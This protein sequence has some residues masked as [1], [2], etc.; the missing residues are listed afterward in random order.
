MKLGD[1]TKTNSAVERRASPVKDT[2]S[3]L[4]GNVCSVTGKRLQQL[5]ENN[6]SR[7]FEW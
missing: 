5:H 1:V 2:P 6:G 4:T 7:T 3:A